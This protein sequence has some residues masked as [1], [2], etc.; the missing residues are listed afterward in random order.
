M[1]KMKINMYKIYDYKHKLQEELTF[2]EISKLYR[3]IL[4]DEY[5]KTTDHDIIHCYQLVRDTIDI[6]TQMT[7]GRKFDKNYLKDNIKW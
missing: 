6:F 1:N 3:E 7:K 4:Y 5:T 2:E